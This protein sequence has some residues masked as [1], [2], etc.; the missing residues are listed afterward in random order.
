MTH[1][2]SARKIKKDS[3]WWEKQL[4]NE[5]RTDPRVFAFFDRRFR[6]TLD[7][8]AS[9]ENAL[10]ERYNSAQDPHRYSWKDGERVFC[11]PPYR[12]PKR[13][14]EYW[15]KMAYS[16]VLT[17][18]TAVLPLPAQVNAGWFHRWACRGEIWIP[19]G[20]VEF[21]PPPGIATT[22]A[23]AKHD[24]I[25]VVMAPDRLSENRLAP[26]VRLIRDWND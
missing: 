9:A 23:G 12:N 7:G 13:R 2:E 1:D 10:C 5:W 25:F 16:A 17:G 3:K 26:T 22:K 8:A 14:I 18:S 21:L 4:R 24:T 11:N 19:E 15:V 6:F 20:R